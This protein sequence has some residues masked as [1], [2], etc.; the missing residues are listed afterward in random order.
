MD[1]IEILNALEKGE[2]R[3]AVPGKDGSWTVNLAV[4]EAILMAFK[5]GKIVDFNEFVDK[6][7]L[8]PQKF[9]TKRGVRIVPYGSTVRRGAYVAEGVVIMPPSYINVGSYV[10]SGCMVDSHVLVGSCAQI[11]KRVH[12]SAGVQIGGVLEPK[13]SIPVI[14][15][16]DVFVGAGTIVVEGLLVKKSAVLAPGLILS[17]GIPVY[18]AVNEEL[19]QRGGPIPENAVVIPGSRPLKS[20]WC[21]DHGICGACAVIIKYRDEGC[22][23]SLLLEEI[24]R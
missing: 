13:G 15:E 5:E 19:L 2:V 17:R 22:N 10:D 16:D 9:N 7:T 4:K 12:L 24:L 3:A 8:L 6:D 21:K 11:G 1:W 14:I 20:K 23:A 18:D